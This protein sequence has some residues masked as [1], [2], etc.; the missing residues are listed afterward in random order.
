MQK[1]DSSRT[2]SNQRVEEISSAFW[3]RYLLKTMPTLNF[4][5]LLS[6]TAKYFTTSL[7]VSDF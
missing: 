1:Y 6:E 5:I 7:V 4:T 3:N 2:I